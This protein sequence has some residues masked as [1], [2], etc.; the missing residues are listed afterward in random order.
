MRSAV[1]AIVFFMGLCFQLKASAMVNDSLTLDNLD[2]FS[3]MPFSLVA[4]GGHQEYCLSL[5]LTNTTNDSIGIYIEPGRVL[6]SEKSDFQDLVVMRSLYFKLPAGKQGKNFIYCFCCSAHRKSPQNGAVFRN[7]YL[8]LSLLGRLG[9]FAN[10]GRYPASD[11]QNC[12][13]AISNN[14]PIAS[15]CEKN[16]GVSPLK[17]W[18]ADQLNKPYPWH[19]IEYDLAD[20]NLMHSRHLR[21]TGIFSF[22][23]SHY[24]TVIIQVR[25]KEGHIVDYIQKNAVYSAGDF[26]YPLDLDVKG[27]PKGVYEILVF[28]DGNRINQPTFFDL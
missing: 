25:T 1:F 12:V 5:S 18:L 3:D 23:V 20:T 7:G 14:Y 27:W 16:K 15:I 26:D 4:L 11:L 9:E 24:A 21:V 6:L 2:A 19:C 22:K 13:W 8:D 10:K 17:K 28:E